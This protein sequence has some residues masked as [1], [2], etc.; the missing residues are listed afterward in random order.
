M[1]LLDWYNKLK[2][3]PSGDQYAKQYGIFKEI[4][5]V[6]LDDTLQLLI[7]N[8]DDR[9]K[10]EI[11]SIM[12]HGGSVKLEDNLILVPFLQR[13]YQEKLSPGLRRRLDW[14]VKVHKY[15]L[16]GRVWNATRAEIMASDPRA[17][18]ATDDRQAKPL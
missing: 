3:T 9:I 4:L 13:L 11:L 2:A 17:T 14:L 6:D 15:P 18:H 10:L 12:G 16:D 7:S 1:K 5:Y 8:I